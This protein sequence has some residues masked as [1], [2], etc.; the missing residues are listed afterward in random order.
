MALIQFQDLPD[1]STPANA[2]NLN[3][4]FNEVKNSNT[5]GTSQSNGYC[6]EYI[7]NGFEANKIKTKVIRS[8]VV[9][10]G[11]VSFDYSS[12]TGTIIAAYFLYAQNSLGN[13]YVTSVVPY[14]SSNRVYP[15]GALVNVSS[16]GSSS[17]TYVYLGVLYYD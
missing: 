6:Q 11:Q 17:T 8:S 16:S 4:N 10:S 3:H 1:T 14:G 2:N 7:N 12:V 15:S 13:T 9:G 5:Y